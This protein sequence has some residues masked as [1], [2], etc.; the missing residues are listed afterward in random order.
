MR[1]FV[2]LLLIAVICSCSDNTEQIQSMQT[3]INGLQKKLDS[4]YTPGFGEF[5]SNIQVHHAKLWFAGIN[6]NWQL[7][8]F[9]VSEIKEGLQDLKKYQAA[10]L[11]INSLPMIYPALDSVYAAVKKENVTDFKNNFSMLTHTCNQCHKTVGYEFNHVK[12]PDS[13][14]FSNQLFTPVQ[15]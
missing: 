6:S 5:M 2:L 13:P 12:I 15:K 3:Q 1:K 8:D 10:R 14:P 9:E 4:L 11:E 7:A